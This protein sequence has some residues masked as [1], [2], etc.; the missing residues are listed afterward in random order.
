MSYLT[1]EYV[2]TSDSGK[3]MRWWVRHTTQG[4]MLGTIQWYAPWRKYVWFPYS[5]STLFDSGCLDEI[6]D[7]LR[8]QNAKHRS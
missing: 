5:S 8:D 4:T 1:F 2:G 3:T 6:A 7:F